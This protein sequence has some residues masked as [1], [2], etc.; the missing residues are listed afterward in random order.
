MDFN[1][2]TFV[3]AIRLS[4]IILKKMHLDL[5]ADISVIGFQI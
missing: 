4:K 3:F 1:C 2:E 5:L